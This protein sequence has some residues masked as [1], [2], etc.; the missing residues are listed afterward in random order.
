MLKISSTRPIVLVSLTAYIKLSLAM[1]LQEDVRSM[2]LAQN[3]DPCVGSVKASQ[4]SNGAN[5]SGDFETED[6]PVECE[7]PDSPW[8]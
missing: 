1:T 5:F 2:R 8:V 7:Y 6:P 3:Y 4:G